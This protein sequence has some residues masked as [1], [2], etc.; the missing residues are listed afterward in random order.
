MQ[1]MIE[2]AESK[3]AKVA[4]GGSTS[5]EFSRGFYFQPTVLTNVNSNMVV[6][7]EETFGPIAPIATFSTLE[8]VLE[9]ANSTPYG[10]AGFVFTSDLNRGLQVGLQLDVGMVGI[11]NLTIA[12][13]EAPFGGVK[14]SG[15]GREGGQEGIEEFLISKYINARM[16][17]VTQ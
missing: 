1:V 7:N 15:F 16:G 6:M 4:L 14:G 5:K 17:K 10:L 11:N 2:D 12:T 3:G 8:E 13:A 9:M